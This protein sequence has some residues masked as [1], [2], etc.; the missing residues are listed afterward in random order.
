M[1]LVILVISV[2]TSTCMV[3]VVLAEKNSPA[4]D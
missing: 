2:I 3:Y 1:L 4:S